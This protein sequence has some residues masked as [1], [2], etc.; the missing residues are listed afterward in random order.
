MNPN[1]IWLNGSPCVFRE[2]DLELVECGPGDAM[3]AAMGALLN[4]EGAYEVLEVLG[5]KG[6][7]PGYEGCVRAHKDALAK[8]KKARIW[9]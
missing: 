6:D 8:I 5:A 9:V 2:A 7:L 4:A 1:A 3:D